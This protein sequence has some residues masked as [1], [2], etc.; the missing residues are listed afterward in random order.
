[1][2]LL[3]FDFDGTIVDSKSVYYNALEKYLEEI[4]FKKKEADESIDIGLSISE[5][6]KK[7]GVSRI[8]RWWTKRKIMGDVLNKVNSVKKCRDVEHLKKLPYEKILISN[9]LLEFIIPVL[10]HL[11]IR[12]EFDEI[13]GADDFKNKEEFI[14]KYLKERKINPQDCFYIGDRVADVKLAKKIKCKS[15]IISNNC[16]W[17]SRKEVLKANPD[18]ILF[19]LKDLKEII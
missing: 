6:L 16:S 17:N 3:I 19:D 9:S 4:G 5:T 8:L 15:I 18:F 12:R 7:L 13:Y 2:K 1:M 14:K 10:N 11:K